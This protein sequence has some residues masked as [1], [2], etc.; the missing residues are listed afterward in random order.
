MYPCKKH[1]SVHVQSRFWRFL[2]E[3][4]LKENH[5]VLQAMLEK[6]I[7]NPGT[8][9]ACVWDCEG[10]KTHC[11]RV[12]KKIMP[13]GELQQFVSKCME[14]SSNYDK[15]FVI[16]A[17]LVDGVVRVSDIRL[18]LTGDIFYDEVY[19]KKLSEPLPD[20]DDGENKTNW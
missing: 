11:D 12:N 18:D 5:A 2:I 9:F 20:A 15:H 14:K 4:K 16:R 6:A 17:G 1:P 8:V 10:L 13:V 7:E 19:W 3:S